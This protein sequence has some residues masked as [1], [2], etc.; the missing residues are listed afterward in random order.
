MKLFFSIISTI[1][2]LNLF[3]ITKD[4]TKYNVKFKQSSEILTAIDE[5]LKYDEFYAISGYMK[6]TLHVAINRRLYQCNPEY[7]VELLQKV[8]VGIK[9][10][11]YKY[12]L[13]VTEDSDV[14]MYDYIY[15]GL[16][17]TITT[18]GFI[19]YDKYEV[20]LQFTE[21]KNKIIFIAVIISAID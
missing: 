2:C 5:H 8:R 12:D 1:M 19:K 10:N 4:T 7:A 3:S 17:R 14:L 21:Y 6:D 13:K 9:N 16:S 18:D 15:I 11:D 20:T